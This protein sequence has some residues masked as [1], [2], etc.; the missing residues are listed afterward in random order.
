MTLLLMVKTLSI[1]NL[2]KMQLVIIAYR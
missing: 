1:T 2:Y